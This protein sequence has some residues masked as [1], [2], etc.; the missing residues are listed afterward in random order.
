[1]QARAGSNQP[2]SR[3]SPP[4]PLA[5]LGCSEGLDDDLDVRRDLK[6]EHAGD[7]EVGSVLECVV[8]AHL[9][10]IAPAAITLKAT[11]GRATVFMN[12]I[13]RSG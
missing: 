7:H 12:A 2:S 13:V 1:M 3:S 4:R 5:Q 9:R 10:G 8:D 11:H 6:I